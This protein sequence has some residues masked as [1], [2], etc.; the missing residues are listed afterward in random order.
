MFYL[1]EMDDFRPLDSLSVT[2]APLDTLQ[3]VVLQISNDD[4]LEQDEYFSLLLVRNTT[5]ANLDTAT[6]I[7][8][9]D[10]SKYV[11][12]SCDVLEFL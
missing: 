8:E 7:I 1:A 12:T 10:D 6:V 4:I 2:F 5:G 11:F 9:N 3:I